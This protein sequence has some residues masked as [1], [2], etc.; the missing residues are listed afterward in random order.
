MRDPCHAVLPNCGLSR[1]FTERQAVTSRRGSR[2]QTSAESHATL[3]DGRASSYALD[4]VAQPTSAQPA[5]YKA[6][7][8]PGPIEPSCYDVEAVRPRST[9][10]GPTSTRWPTIRARRPPGFSSHRR[11]DRRFLSQ[12]SS[13]T[14]AGS[15]LLRS[16]QERLTTKRGRSSGTDR[17]PPVS[18]REAATSRHWLASRLGRHSR[19]LAQP[20]VIMSRWHTMGNSLGLA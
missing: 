19:T 8:R 15:T 20:N 1:A 17:S 4:R 16:L 3:R 13:Q 11:E 7:Q 14:A 9:S 5:L 6:Y 10:S 2:S 18:A 12:S